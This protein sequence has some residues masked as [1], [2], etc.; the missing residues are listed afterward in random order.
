M[1]LFN[2]ILFHC[3]VEDSSS[4]YQNPKAAYNSFMSIS[5]ISRWYMVLNDTVLLNL[6]KIASGQAEKLRLKDWRSIKTTQLVI[7]TYMHLMKV[8]CQALEIIE[9]ISP[10]IFFEV[11][12]E[13]LARDKHDSQDCRLVLRLAVKG[14]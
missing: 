13:A 2:C 9:A 6:A 11:E 8:F 7:P 14:C 4:K 12:P 10:S 5:R 1:A 3:L